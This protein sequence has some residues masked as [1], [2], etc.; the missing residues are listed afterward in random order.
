MDTAVPE[1]APSFALPGS[2]EFRQAHGY[3]DERGQGRAEPGSP[4]LACGYST[5]PRRGRPACHSR[6][7]A[8]F[9]AEDRPKTRSGAGAWPR[10]T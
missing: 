6:M 8:G 2:R 10:V 1:Y 9:Q 7:A 3:E 5:E 4:D